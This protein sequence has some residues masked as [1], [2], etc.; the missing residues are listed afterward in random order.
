MDLMTDSRIPAIIRSHIVE[1][2]NR[3][4]NMADGT[5]LTTI[6]GNQ[7]T[8]SNGGALNVDWFQTLLLTHG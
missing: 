1:G 3:L 4:A 5:V 6:A 2:P 8:I 7:L